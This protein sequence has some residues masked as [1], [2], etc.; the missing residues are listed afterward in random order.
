[1][2]I[3]RSESLFMP[4][5]SSGAGAVGLMQLL[6]GTGRQTARRAGI[7]YRGRE[8]LL[9]PA[10]NVALGTR[11]LAEML[12]RFDDHRVLATAA[13][14]AGPARVDR[15]LPHDG[16][17][18][19]EAWVDSVPY[20]ETRGYIQRVLASEAVF[21]WRLSGETVRITEAMRPVPA[22]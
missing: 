10:G 9:D 21:Q 11:Y 8:T 5:V 22:R 13:Y 17:L 3:A 15:W 16:V 6:P 18:P 14:N 4:D 19:A 12:A 20:N 1:Y 7:T 2:G